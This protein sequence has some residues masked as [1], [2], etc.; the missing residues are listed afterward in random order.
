VE[1]TSYE[2]YGEV[3]TGGTKSKFG[4]TGQEKDQETGLNYYD[5]RYYDPH[6]HRFTQPDT[7]LPDVYDPQ[8]LNRYAYA[9]NN[10]IKYI[11]PTGNFG[12]IPFLQSIYFSAVNL[13]ARFAPTLQSTS[14]KITRSQVTQKAVQNADKIQSNPATVKTE[15]RVTSLATKALTNP[16]SSKGSLIEKVT[17]TSSSV[18]TNINIGEHIKGQMQN[19]GWTRDLIEETI[20]NPARKVTNLRDTRNIENG[21]KMDDPAT[22]YVAE[23]GSY[24]IINNVT[25]DV[26]QISNKFKPGWKA[27]WDKVK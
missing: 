8:Q 23:D 17:N 24:V 5:A 26:V 27:P 16:S 7:L 4:Y 6:I 9:R 19:R 3:K 14:T 18:K 22:G 2:P 10:P 12:I 1:K 15:E 21:L 25:H 11:D 20:K 13:V